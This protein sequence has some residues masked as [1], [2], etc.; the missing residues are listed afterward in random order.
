MSESAELNDQEHGLRTEPS[1]CIYDK[2]LGEADNMEKIQ[3]KMERS[4]T[5]GENIAT[6]F[7]FGRDAMRIIEEDEEEEEEDRAS[8]RFKKIPDENQ[9]AYMNPTKGERGDEA[10]PSKLR[11]HA[12]YLESTGDLYG[13]EECYIQAIEAY[14]KDGKILSQYAKLVWQLHGDQPRALRYF[15]KAV[16]AAPQDSNVLAA[17][18]SFLWDIENDEEERLSDTQ[19]D[20]NHVL[21][22]P[23]AMDFKEE[24]MPSSPTLHLA[25]GLGINHAGFFS[26]ND[27]F[28]H[29]NTHSDESINA[30]EY[31]RRMVE[32][33]PRNPFFLRNY[34]LFLHQVKGD[35]ERAE[36]YYSRGILEDPRDGQM[37][38]LYAGIVWQ[39]YRDKYKASTYFERAVEVTPN[40]SNVLAAY[41]KFLWENEEEED[42]IE[43]A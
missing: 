26:F 7:S 36:E 15:E 18:A 6:Q 32:E 3:E 41:A 25:M 29:M 43:D 24:M 2:F 27:A 19:G 12:Q 5:I 40:D 35:I 33:N 10:G 22:D 39:L 17:Y 13:A 37:L 8:N 23:S 34:A 42:M 11:K 1:F 28:D 30:E 31:H 16:G 9:D 21:V 4:A 20:E 14:P 38:S